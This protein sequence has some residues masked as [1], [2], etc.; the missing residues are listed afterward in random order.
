MRPGTGSVAIRLTA[1]PP[2]N[3]PGTLSTAVRAS[4]MH[5]P[6][7]GQVRATIFRYVTDDRA[8]FDSARA[9]EKV[10]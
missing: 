5:R 3:P 10:D 9:A 7:D 4:S 1:N 2:T 8:D 6:G